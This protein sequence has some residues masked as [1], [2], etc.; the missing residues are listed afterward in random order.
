VQLAKGDQ[1][2][3]DIRADKVDRKYIWQW[4]TKVYAGDQ[5]K[6]VKADFKQSDMDFSGFKLEQLE[7]RASVHI[8]TCSET[9]DIDR[10]VLNQMTGSAS[11]QDIAQK[12]A[13]KFPHKYSDWKEAFNVVGE[14]STK[15][16]K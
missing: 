7:K 8:P 2:I 6:R 15:Y 5:T 10:F 13:D 11:L 14:L 4:H 12:L 1:I 3:I 9:G 16:S